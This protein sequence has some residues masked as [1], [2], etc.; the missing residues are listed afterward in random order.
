MYWY[1]YAATQGVAE[2]ECRG[3]RRRRGGG[4]AFSKGSTA[5]KGYT[6][7]N[8]GSIYSCSV[9]GRSA[10]IAEVRKNADAPKE[11]GAATGADA[12][13]IDVSGDLRGNPGRDCCSVDSPPV[14][15]RAPHFF[16]FLFGGGKPQRHTRVRRRPENS[17]SEFCSG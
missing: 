12:T 10:N 13:C 7:F 9:A 6:P 15:R 17:E 16:I 1:V 14:L 11:V 5:I 4:L 3:C 2:G 8:K